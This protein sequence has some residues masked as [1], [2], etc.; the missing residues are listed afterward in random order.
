[1][2]GGEDRAGQGIHTPDVSGGFNTRLV[3]RLCKAPADI[4]GFLEACAMGNLSR[5]EALLEKGVD[6][7]TTGVEGGPE[8]L[9]N[10]SGLMMAAMAGQARVL[11]KLLTIQTVDV[12]RR[13]K[14]GDTALTIAALQGC[15]ECVALLLRSGAD[16]SAVNHSGKSSLGLL[17]DHVRMEEFLEV[18]TLHHG[19]LIL[20]VRFVEHWSLQAAEEQTRTGRY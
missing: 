8:T 14:N 9:S 12:N 2:V 17:A 15:E 19:H 11:E 18:C 5:V 6:V 7:N 13:G 1:M 10:T 20:L 16:P 3:T 4:M